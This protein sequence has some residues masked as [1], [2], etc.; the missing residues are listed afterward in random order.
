MGPRHEPL[1]HPLVIL[2]AMSKF[3]VSTNDLQGAV[4]GDF[5][6][7]PTGELVARYGLVCDAEKADGTGCGCGRAFGGLV[8]NRSTTTAKVMELPIDEAGWRAEVHRMLQETDWARGLSLTELADYIDWM[9]ER[10]VVPIQELPVGT[11]VGRRAW[12]EAG[13]LRS[14]ELLIR[15]TPEANSWLD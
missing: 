9:V 15:F 13:A 1:S 5:T 12:N 14:D 6:W 7:V 4:R 10:D 8:T 3:L 11:I 2:D